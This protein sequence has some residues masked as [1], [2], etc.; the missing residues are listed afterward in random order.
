VGG[1]RRRIG[2]VAVAVLVAS[3]GFEVSVSALAMGLNYL[4][5]LWVLALAVQLWRRAR[6]PPSG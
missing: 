4:L 3:R 1:G 6:Q 2:W 5:G